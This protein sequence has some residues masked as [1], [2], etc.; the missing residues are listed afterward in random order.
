MLNNGLK[1]GEVF[2][3]LTNR[4]RLLECT[5]TQNKNGKALCM[6]GYV[7]FMATPN[8]GRYNGKDMVT[9]KI[10]ENCYMEL[11]VIEGIKNKKPFKNN[12]N[13]YFFNSA[14]ALKYLQSL[15]T[16]AI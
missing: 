12:G 8:N 15:N 4:N 14:T 2:Y 13:Y 10:W 11:A 7:D 5:V 1:L 6:Y 16:P 9:G 3:M